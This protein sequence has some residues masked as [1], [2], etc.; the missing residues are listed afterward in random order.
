MLSN[1]RCEK[2]VLREV[3]DERASWRICFVC[4]TREE[5]RGGIVGTSLL[6]K[7]SIGPNTPYKR[8]REDKVQSLA[9]LKFD[10]L[11]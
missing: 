3:T 6:A 8:V 10:P 11:P 5:M 1:K 4:E 9:D 7:K 2:L